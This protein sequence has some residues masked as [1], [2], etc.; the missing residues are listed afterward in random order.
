MNRVIVDCSEGME[1]PVW[2]DEIEV[3]AEKI[4]TYLKKSA[5]EVSVLF[6]TDSFIQSLNKEY[7]KIDSPTDILSFEDGDEYIDEENQKW[8]AAG[9]IAI[10][11][12]TMKKNADSFGVSYNEELKRLIIHGI[13]HLSG[14][15]HGEAHIGENKTLVDGTPDEQKMLIEQE[16]ILS[17]F[18]E[19]IIIK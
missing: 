5:W 19:D 15:D 10:S 18:A 6:C 13:L 2:I 7:R 1:P 14:M 8:F 4:L 12:E 9:D 16:E 11:I 17:H 3:F